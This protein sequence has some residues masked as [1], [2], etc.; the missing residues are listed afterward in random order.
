VSNIFALLTTAFV[1]NTTTQVY[2]GKTLAVYVS[3]ITVQIL[4]WSGDQQP[5]ELGPSY[6][7]EETFAI[8]MEIAS[9]AGDQN[10]MARQTEV[11]AAFGVVSMTVANNWTLPSTAGG[12]DGAVRFAEVGTFSFIPEADNSGRS[13]GLLTFDVH[14]SQRIASLT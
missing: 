11:M 8:Q 13:I 6:R 14:C 1:A 2:M 5:A 9:W 4:G 7:R 3:P 10:Y 12:N